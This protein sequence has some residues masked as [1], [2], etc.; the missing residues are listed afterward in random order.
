M[1][2]KD[3]IF[4]EYLLKD[5]SFIL[6]SYCNS[7]EKD[8]YWDEYIK[9]NPDKS[10]IIYEAREKIRSVKFNKYSLSEAEKSFLKIRINTSIEKRKSKR[11]IHKLIPYAVAASIIGFVFIGLLFQNKLHTDAYYAQAIEPQIEDSQQEIEL[12]LSSQQKVEL[13]NKCDIKVNKEGNVKVK[14]KLIASLSKEDGKVKAY[15]DNKKMNI[16]KV[17]KGRHSSLTLPDGSKLWINAGTV[18]QF[19]S[20]FDKKHRTIYVNGEVF[21]NVTHDSLCPFHVVTSKIDVHV[22]GTQFNVTAYEEEP[23]HCVVLKEGKVAVETKNNI[24]KTLKPNEKFLFDGES[25]EISKVD[26][27]DY[28]S[29]TKGFLQFKQIPV[30]EILTKVSKYY[31]VNIVCPPKI[32]SQRCSGKLVLFNNIQDVM[33]TLKDILNISYRIEEDKIILNVEP[34]KIK[35]S[36]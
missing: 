30:S 11:F 5:E 17:P 14:S 10:E 7:E 26:V 34:E 29:W 33:Q 1:D 24:Q 27:D 36:L 25:M 31:R 22:L 12:I 35:E 15:K 2:Q 21:L 16:L 9:A 13:V 18:V 8:S 6:W 32:K 4:F 23:S 20:E 3:T 28:I 19:P